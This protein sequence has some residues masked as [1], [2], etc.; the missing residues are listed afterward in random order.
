VLIRPEAL[1]LAGGVES[2]RP[3]VI[4]DCSLARM[5]KRSGGKLYLG[6]SNLTA[7][8]A[9]TNRSLRSVG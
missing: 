7:A 9:G 4:D 5:V 6:V 8:F 1:A 2:I 3:E